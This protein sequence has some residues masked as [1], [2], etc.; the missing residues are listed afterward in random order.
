MKKA[1]LIEC[2]NIW[3][4]SLLKV[5]LN[6]GNKKKVD[7][8]IRADY[9]FTDEIIWIKPNKNM[10]AHKYHTLTT[11]SE[12]HYQTPSSYV[13]CQSIGYMGWHDFIIQEHSIWQNVWYAYR[14]KN[15][16]IG[17]ECLLARR[18]L[19]KHVSWQKGVTNV[20]IS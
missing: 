14:M 16:R 19:F 3:L 8:K 6:R 9:I 10:Y 17:K 2:N 12:S 7:S 18:S 4:Q 5:Y 20:V 13:T 11:V 15:N 1:Q